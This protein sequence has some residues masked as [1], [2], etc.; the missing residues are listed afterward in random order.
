MLIPTAVS[1]D[2]SKVVPNAVPT[3]V[4]TDNSNGVPNAD[5]NADSYCCLY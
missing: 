2:N 5:P 4:S 1:T 3:A